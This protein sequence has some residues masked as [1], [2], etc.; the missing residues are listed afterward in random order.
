MTNMSPRFLQVRL[1]VPEASSLRRAL[2]KRLF[3]QKAIY[4]LEAPQIR[5]LSNA[6]PALNQR[7]CDLYLLCELALSASVRVRFTPSLSDATCLQ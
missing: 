3:S 2:N 1:S 6:S 5:K 7:Q 4:S